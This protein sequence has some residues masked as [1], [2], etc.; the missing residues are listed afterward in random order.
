LTIAST[1]VIPELQYW[2]N[3]FI[4]ESIVNKNG[5]PTPSAIDSLYLP[6]NS[7]IELLF[8]DAYPWDEYKYI[9]K[10][11]PRGSWPTPISVRLNLYPA[12]AKYFELSQ[13]STGDNLFLLEDEELTMLD[14]LLAYRMDSSSVIIIDSTSDIVFDS[15]ADILFC[16]YDLL[17][18]P[19]SQLIYLYLDLKI[20]N[21]FSSYD[22]TTLVSQGTLLESFYELY[23]LD[24]FF[25]FTTAQY[26]TLG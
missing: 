17:S 13:D 14:A 2:L 18:T 4:V 5:V 23:V 19:L 25:K 6:Q 1:I 15:T 7:F 26:L 16:N 20:N 24:Q 9:Y 10:Q 3:K 11:Q 8:N 21:N 22:N 12:S